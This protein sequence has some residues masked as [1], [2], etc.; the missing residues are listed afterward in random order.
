MLL[1]AASIA[2][3]THKLMALQFSIQPLFVM[4]LPM[5]SSPRLGTGPVGQCPH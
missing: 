4:C 3:I 5:V 1:G 2:S